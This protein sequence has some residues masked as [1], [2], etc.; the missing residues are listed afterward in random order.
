MEN[1]YIKFLKNRDNWT[2]LQDS[3]V[4]INNLQKKLSNLVN[5]MS[6]K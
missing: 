5:Y 6:S 2:L 4:N 3:L 1:T